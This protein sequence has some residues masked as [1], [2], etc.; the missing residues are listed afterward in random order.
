VETVVVV[1][2]VEKRERKMQLEDNDDDI[3]S[4]ALKLSLSGVTYFNPLNPDYEH[5]MPMKE[6][7]GSDLNNST[8]KKERS[9]HKRRH[10]MEMIKLNNENVRCTYKITSKR[11]MKIIF[12]II[13]ILFIAFIIISKIAAG[14]FIEQTPIAFVFTL[15]QFA[16]ISILFGNRYQEVNGLKKTP[17]KKTLFP[18][19]ILLVLVFII[20]QLRPILWNV[21]E[22]VRTAN[23]VLGRKNCIV[24]NRHRKTGLK[25]LCFDKMKPP[26]VIKEIQNVDIEKTDRLFSKFYN[27][28]AATL[29]TGDEGKCLD[30]CSTYLCNVYFPRCDATCGRVRECDMCPIISEC[31][32][33]TTDLFSKIH[34]IKKSSYYDSLIE[35]LG[36]ED[37]DS[38][39]E[40]AR[41]MDTFLKAVVDIENKTQDGRSA[42]CNITHEKV[43]NVSKECLHL[44]HNEVKKPSIYKLKQGNCH[45]SNLIDKAIQ[46]DTSVVKISFQ[47]GKACFY[48]LM[49]SSLSL[50]SI[51]III[52]ATLMPCR[53]EMKQPVLS[54]FYGR[55]RVECAMTLSE[56]LQL[57]VTGCMSAFVGYVMFQYG[58]YIEIYSL[59]ESNLTSEV[60]Y[61]IC[62]YII[63]SVSF[64]QATLILLDGIS[65]FAV[66]QFSV[67][68]QQQDRQN[69]NN[70]SKIIF[71]LYQNLFSLKYG[72]YFFEKLFVLEIGEIILQYLSLRQL[73][74]DANLQ[75]IVMVIVLITLNVTIS[76]ILMV[77]RNQYKTNAKYV[78][79]LF[80]SSLDVL[81]LFA[82]ITRGGEGSHSRNINLNASVN[83]AMWYPAFSIVLRLRSVRRA[84]TMKQETKFKTQENTTRKSTAAK[85]HYSMHRVIEVVMAA[86]TICG[87][88]IFCIS[89][90]V[91]FLSKYN[92]CRNEFT[93]QLWDN[94]LPKKMFKYGLFRPNCGYDSILKIDANEKNVEI[95]PPIIEKCTNLTT[96]NLQNN[97]IKDIPCELLVME[98]IQKASFDGN[99]VARN[100]DIKCSLQVEIFPTKFVCKFLHK[101][102]E[103]LKFPNQTAILKI[104][105]CLG[106]FHKLQSLI[107]PYNTELKSDGIPSEILKLYRN[108]LKTFNI[109]GNEKLL[110]SF[111]WGSEGISR[112]LHTNMTNFILQYFRG[113]RVLNLSGN[114]IDDNNIFYNLLLH[115]KKLEYLNMSFNAFNSIQP[116]MLYNMTNTSWANLKGVD[117]SSNKMLTYVSLTFSQ[118]IEKRNVDINLKDSQNLIFL[119]W[120]SG[121]L[122]EDQKNDQQ[123]YNYYKSTIFPVSIIRQLLYLQTYT[124]DG[125][126]RLYFN[127]KDLK[128]VC[129]L[130]SLKL[131]HIDTIGFNITNIPFSCGIGLENIHI[132]ALDN[133][134]ATASYSWPDVWSNST[135]LKALYI[136]SPTNLKMLPFT[137]SSTIESVTIWG[138]NQNDILR[139]L[140]NWIFSGMSK[141]LYNIQLEDNRIGGNL[142]HTM[143]SNNSK[144][145][146]VAMDVN[147]LAGS[148]PASLFDMPC[149]RILALKKNELAGHLPNITKTRM[150]RIRCMNIV[151]NSGLKPF[152]SNDFFHIGGYF[153]FSSSLFLKKN[154]TNIC[155]VKIEEIYDK[156]KGWR[157]DIYKCGTMNCYISNDRTEEVAC[158]DIKYKLLK[159]QL[160]FD[161]LRTYLC[162]VHTVRGYLPDD[163]SKCGD[164]SF[165]EQYPM[166][167]FLL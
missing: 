117:L 113:V 49:S 3:I 161:T 8:S 58:Y 40:A 65:G 114:N 63:A 101:N 50:I 55:N 70:E 123:V 149:L 47:C 131:L 77:C 150:K 83:L 135:K 52:G 18:F 139:V 37:T 93:H 157:V 56:R 43:K 44:E 142:S 160:D 31:G 72:K 30:Y 45:E 85:K 10:S 48:I 69:S 46:E 22:N 25:S 21:E 23:N 141:A 164:S 130:P 165:N 105:K 76:P 71:Q 74:Y 26:F 104:N 19:I 79:Y 155:G 16:F 124:L 75:Y 17:M 6:K 61:I 90:L 1:K 137:A 35:T 162:D 29:A 12:G 151:S 54:R 122:L 163:L 121:G 80:D 127:S 108:K 120:R 51:L 118:F 100:M 91:E 84:I 152:Q 4:D 96:L 132:K 57:L 144:L 145:I 7:P 2:Q 88:G 95:I 110:E 87:G 156:D 11:S 153:E 9:R 13:L 129:D 81:Y 159:S 133:P 62:S 14:E 28:L 64:F 102:L 158:F 115:L 53:N 111:S 68:L 98:D 67:G 24:I 107:L 119:G 34:G 36:D 82:N 20:G 89:F 38:L 166:P 126:P 140:P 147:N 109:K 138:D 103:I 27:L 15:S 32:T 59:T 78:L 60:F 146:R 86:F 136:S 143:F 112:D 99:E 167:S 39:D 41:F 94:A 73:C 125:F 116:N 97:N 66:I 154:I 5:K 33:T 148:L 92:H 134:L 128:A 106:D 42:D